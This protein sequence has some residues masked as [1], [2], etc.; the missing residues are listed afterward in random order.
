LL[1]GVGDDVERLDPWYQGQ[2][3]QGI[4]VPSYMDATTL[5]HLNETEANQ[6]LGLKPSSAV[7]GVISDQVIPAYDLEQ[8]L[9]E[10]STEGMLTEVGRRINGRKD[11]ACIA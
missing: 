10:A 9:V 3:R 5:D 7:M 6:V 1:G 8:K 2:T 4:R 11:F